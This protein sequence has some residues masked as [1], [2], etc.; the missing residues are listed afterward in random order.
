MFKDIKTL[1]PKSVKRA[2]ISG[3]VLTSGALAVFREE[4]GKILG[5]G[6]SDKVKPLYIRH[7]TL[8]AATLSSAAALKLQTNEK[9]IIRKINR[10]CG[11]K[12]VKKIK[13][14]A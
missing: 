3:K 8:V 7:G 14:L 9:K 5:E 12:E 10:F 11:D 2:G 13:Y 6:V 4:A 1:L